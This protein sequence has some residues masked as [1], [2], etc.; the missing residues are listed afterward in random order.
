MR[1]TCPRRSS[2]SPIQSSGIQGGPLP[3]LPKVAAGGLPLAR[4]KKRKPKLVWGTAVRGQRRERQAT[5]Q[6]GLAVYWRW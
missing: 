6:G 1:F 4:E 3:F 5:E 2:P